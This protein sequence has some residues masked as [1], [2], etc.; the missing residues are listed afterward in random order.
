MI[1]KSTASKAVSTTVHEEFLKGNIPSD[2]DIEKPA[3]HPGLAQRFHGRSHYM[4]QPYYTR[5]QLDKVAITH[6][7]TEGV[8]DKIALTGVGIMRS[9]FDYITGYPE[10]K[11]K[12]DW[13]NRIVF[14]E[15]VAGVPGM[16]AGMLR[17]MSSLRS[18]QRDHG[19]IHT[20]LEEAENERMHLMTFLR[21]R[22]PGILFRGAVLATQGVFFNGFLMVYLLAPRLCHRFVGYLEEEAVRTYTHCLEVIDTPGSPLAE[23]ATEPAP[24]VAR[25]YWKLPDTA[26]MR[27]VVEVVRA[28][29]ACHRHVNHT[30]AAIDIED[31]NPF[32]EGG[33]TELG[34]GKGEKVERV[35][36]K[37]SKQ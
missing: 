20:L 29:E 4:K 22:H 5:E 33:L 37:N 11:T 15:T 18:M 7:P 19:W 14:L 28:D 21:V 9:S 32:G 12:R 6:R 13:L 16:V 3:P 8:V 30:F 2:A 35:V 17:H 23:W 34:I 27:D 36:G 1:S 10:L 24:I 26:T 31:P 25:E